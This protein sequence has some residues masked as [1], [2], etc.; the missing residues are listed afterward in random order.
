VRV[1]NGARPLYL[2]PNMCL[3]CLFC[4]DL[5]PLIYRLNPLENGGIEGR[6]FVWAVRL[7]FF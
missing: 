5:P 3:L 6:F 4:E 1:C 2:E 7:C